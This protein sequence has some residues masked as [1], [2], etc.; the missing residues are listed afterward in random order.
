M[1]CSF[2]EVSLEAIVASTDDFKPSILNI[3]QDDVRK[4]IN[5][6]IDSVGSIK[7]FCFDDSLT[8]MQKSFCSYVSCQVIWDDLQQRF[9]ALVLFFG[10]QHSQGFVVENSQ[11]NIVLL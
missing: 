2:S 9:Y 3:I 5:V 10:L 1:H 7:I 4:V 11:E 6:F 8:N